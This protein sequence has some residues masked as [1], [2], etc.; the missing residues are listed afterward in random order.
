[1]EARERLARALGDRVVVGGLCHV[2]ASREAPGQV[3]VAGAPF[4]LTWGEPTS[5]TSE[6]LE[7][8]SALLRDAGMTVTLSPQIAVALWS[9][10]LFVEPFGSVGAATR[11]SIDIV[12]TLPETRTLLETA[13][14]EIG[15]VA[16][17]RGIPLPKEVL[18]DSMARVDSMPPGATASMHRDLVEGRPSE[19]SDQTGAVVRLGRQAG[20]ATPVHDVLWATLLPQDRRLT[21]V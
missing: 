11:S 9:K 21:V 14:R 15:V 4:H 16:E 1:V 10:L 6:R 2:L 17:A 5:P 13:M 18:A 19:L 3:S 12:R 8:L 20:V 7:H